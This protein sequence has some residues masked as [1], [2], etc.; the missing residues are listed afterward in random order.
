MAT[1]SKSFSNNSKYTLILTVTE[2]ANSTNIANNTTDVKWEL[3]MTSGGASFASW[4]VDSTVTINGETVLDNS[5]KTSISANSSLILGSGTKTIKHNDDGKKT[6]SCS[7]SAST[8]TSQTY[9][10][11]SAS[12]SGDLILTEIPRESEVTCPSFNAGS[13]TNIVVTK[14]K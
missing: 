8:L 9:L 1:F 3:K 14:K 7:G 5:V 6:I 13:S 10:P 2:V 11:G 12:V 4:Y